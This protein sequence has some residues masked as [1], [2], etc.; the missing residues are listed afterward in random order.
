MS[1]F[2]EK[3]K[4]KSTLLSD[5]IKQLSAEKGTTKI[6]DITVAQVIQGMRDMVGMLTQTSDVDAIEGVRFRGY[7]ITQLQDLLPKSSPTGEP[8]PEGVLYLML[9]GE[10]PTPQD[11]ANLSAE[12]AQRAQ[13]PDAAK[14]ALDALPTT[15]HPMTQLSIGIMALQPHSTFAQNYAKIPRTQH[16]EYVFEDA[17]NL[18][19]AIPYVAAYIYRRTYKNNEHIPANPNLDWAANFAHMLGYP[20]PQFAD[21][22]RLYL[23][24]HADHEGGNVSAHTCHLVGSA[25]SDPY[26]CFAA[27]MNGLAGPLHGKANQDAVHWIMEMRQIT[28]SNRPTQDQIAQY[29]RDIIAQKRTVA[30]YG[31]AVLRRTDPRFTAQMEFAKKHFPD[32]ELVNTVWDIYAVTPQ[33]LAEV[34]RARNVFPNVDAHSGAMLMHY[35][36]TEYDFYTVLFGVS[37]ALGVMSSLC[38]SRFLAL[39]IERPG[40][41]TYE[42][43]QELANAATTN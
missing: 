1:N 16:W 9:I 43:L 36:F 40:S 24:I 31:H 5:K 19:A 15:M 41:V 32:D 6:G 8:L 10:L 28:G 38:I 3:F 11:V 14:K 12:L 34:T 17:L 23:F 7:S 39:P 25:H 29:V 18:I 21:L 42:A 4:E 20:S 26:L 27:A 33:V 35:G 30:G 13:M 2:K 22:M 37:R